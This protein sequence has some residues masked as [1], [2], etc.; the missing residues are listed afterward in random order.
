MILL[1]T[2]HARPAQPLCWAF[3][4]DPPVVCL[5][6]RFK[7]EFLCACFWKY[8]RCILLRSLWEYTGLFLNRTNVWAPNLA[9]PCP[10]IP[11]GDPTRS[12]CCM[13]RFCTRQ[14]ISLRAYIGITF[15]CMHKDVQRYSKHTKQNMCFTLCP[16]CNQE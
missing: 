7:T 13:Y 14:M 3:R 4:P 6:F 9:P 11:L 1:A 12:A 16:L 5:G 15:S 2:I 10:A 8:A